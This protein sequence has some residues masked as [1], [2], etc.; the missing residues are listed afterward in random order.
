MHITLHLTTSCNLSCDY[1]YASHSG[2]G[3]SMSEETAIKSVEFATNSMSKNIGI[4][5]FGGE[6]LLKKDIIKATVN[7]CRRLELKDP[8]KYKFHY[9]ITTNGL[10]LDDEFLQYALKN[11]IV[12]SLSIDGIKESHDRHRKTK[13][14]EATHHIVSEK[15][16]K[17]L[18]YQ[19]YANAFMVITPENVDHYYESVKYL[20]EKGF[21]YIIAS[22][23]YAGD[24]RERHF[25][26][27]KKQYKKLARYYKLLTLKEKKFF[28]SPFEMKLSTHIKGKDILCTDCH[29]AQKQVSIAPDGDIYPCVQFVQDAVSNKDFVIGNVYTGFD[30]EKRNSIYVESQVPEDNCNL[31]SIKSRCNY[32][33]SCLNWQTTGKINQPSY[34][35]C[36]TEKIIVPI[37]DKLGEVL[38]KK[39]AASFIQK[40][41][42]TAYSIFSLMEDDRWK[43]TGN[44]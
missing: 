2:N 22:L 35:L 9:K 19:P 29:L 10:L 6:P 15:I 42:N 4:I 3:I 5:F 12:I 25:I 38:F 23:N 20:I 44:S 14:G 37:T 34:V 1:C 13:E 41:Y 26:K 27:L 36:E 16:D 39:K 24:W 18:S 7:E 11:N 8:L 30:Q 33:C 31:C 28:F 43:I 17:L 32:K 40:H 21:V